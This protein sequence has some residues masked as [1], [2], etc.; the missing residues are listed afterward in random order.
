MAVG[1][2]VDSLS[3]GLA[4]TDISA[5]TEELHAMVHTAELIDCTV[6]LS[7]THA[8]MSIDPDQS[9]SHDN[10]THLTPF[11]NLIIL[12]YLRLRGSILCIIK[13]RFNDF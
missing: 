2:S 9:S 7:P 5:L 4:V 8:T 12:S 6:H 11:M 13:K 10:N 1:D 3:L